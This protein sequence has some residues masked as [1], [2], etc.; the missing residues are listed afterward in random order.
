MEETE[1][2]EITELIRQKYLTHAKRDVLISLLKDIALLK[3]KSCVVKIGKLEGIEDVIYFADIIEYEDE[4]K[5]SQTTYGFMAIDIKEFGV[6]VEQ[7]NDEIFFVKPSFKYIIGVNSK[8]KF[9]LKRTGFLPKLEYEFHTLET[10]Y[11]KKY[12][13]GMDTILMSVNLED[14]VDGYMNNYISF[15]TK[16]KEDLEYVPLI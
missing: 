10:T 3:E 13:I 12:E 4:H 8:H 6:I 1:E 5:N 2:N 11:D 7:F 16:L 15:L 14:Q 9:E